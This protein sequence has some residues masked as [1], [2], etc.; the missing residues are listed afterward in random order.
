MTWAD[1][2]KKIISLESPDGNTFEALWAGDERI[3]S[4]KLG[5]FEM[6]DVKGAIVQDLEVGGT[7]HP[8]S[9]YFDG[10]DNDIVAQ[11]FFVACS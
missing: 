1:R 8:I 9:I 11:S 7:R 6:P 5:I 3:L 4:K 2:I 10:P